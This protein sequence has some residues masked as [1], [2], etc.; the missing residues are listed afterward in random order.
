MNNLT[1]NCITLMNNS[2]VTLHIQTPSGESIRRVFPKYETVDSLVRSM[3][4]Y[5]HNCDIGIQTEIL[6]DHDKNQ[7]T[8]K[9]KETPENATCGCCP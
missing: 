1:S 7:P 8:I 3:H 2:I 9:K 6:D 4:V 5:L